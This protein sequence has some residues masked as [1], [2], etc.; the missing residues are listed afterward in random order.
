VKINIFCEEVESPQIKKSLILDICKKISTD[1]NVIFSNINIIFCSDEYLLNINKEYLQHDY[2]TDIITFD[3]KNK[4]SVSSDM[5]ISLDRV[6][7]N[8]LSVSVAFD[9]ELT[10][11]IIHGLLHLSGYEDN[12]VEKRKNMSFREDY[13][14]AKLV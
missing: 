7:E 11:I 9:F 2:Y 1:E 14:L 8:A 10:R 12:T 13:F 4:K 6:R 3:Y 5:F